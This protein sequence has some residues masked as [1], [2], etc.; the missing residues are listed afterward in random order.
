[1]MSVRDA[2]SLLIER[3]SHD[4]NPTDQHALEHILSHGNLSER[5]LRACGS[6]FSRTH[7]IN[8]YRELGQCL[9][10][11]QQFGAL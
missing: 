3:V 5:I 1:P 2:W 9:I 7:L 11:N 10:S 8:V 4:L 6:D